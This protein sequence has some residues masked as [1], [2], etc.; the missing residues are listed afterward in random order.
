MLSHWRINST[1]QCSDRITAICD[2]MPCQKCIKKF[3]TWKRVT[4]SYKMKYISIEEKL[5]CSLF[6]TS[7]IQ[8]ILVSQW[9]SQRTTALFLHYQFWYVFKPIFL[10]LFYLIRRKVSLL[11]GWNIIYNLL[12]KWQWNVL[13]YSCTYWH[14]MTKQLELHY[15]II[16]RIRVLF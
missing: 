5:I 3:C 9:Y 8:G 2:G 1:T 6:R 7:E 13:I 4:N 12:Y 15:I 11:Q 14:E 16:W 10:L